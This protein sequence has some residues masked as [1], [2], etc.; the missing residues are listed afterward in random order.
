[1]K[2]VSKAVE[3]VNTE[4]IESRSGWGCWIPQQRW[5]D[6]LRAAKPETLPATHS[7]FF[8][9]EQRVKTVRG[10]G[11]Q[12]SVECPEIRFPVFFQCAELWEFEGCK[13]KAY[14]DPY[15]DP[16]LGT[17]TLE[18]AQWRGFK[19]GHIIA[20]DVPA[21]ELP[22]QA[23]FCDDWTSASAERS[24]AIR[25]AISKA[26]RTETWNYLGQRTSQARDGHGALATA[27]SSSSPLNGERVGV[28]DETE[29]C[30]PT[31]PPPQ[32]RSRLAAPT[33][34]QFARRAARIAEDAALARDL[35][36]PG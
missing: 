23:V 2:H 19:R 34:E 5:D 10:G 29:P 25:K 12:F 16:V 14:F 8:A 17:L 27:T 9:R 36:L 30:A 4:P 11:L 3:F 18:D 31:A 24:L 32:P 20:R 28:R 22:P 7:I 35:G 6:S 33:P 15:A 26:V 13:V 21:L 1:V